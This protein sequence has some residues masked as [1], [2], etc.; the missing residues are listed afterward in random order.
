MTHLLRTGLVARASRLLW[1]ER[2][3]PTGVGGETPAYMQCCHPR[4]NK[5]KKEELKKC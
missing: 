3:A 2:R 1:R 4:A 5:L